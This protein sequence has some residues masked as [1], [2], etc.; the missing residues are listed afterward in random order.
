MTTIAAKALPGRTTYIG[1][2]SIKDQDTVLLVLEDLSQEDKELV[3]RQYQ[4]RYLTMSDADVQLLLD[5]YVVGG[6]N[7]A[8]TEGRIGAANGVAPLDSTVH[9]PAQY[10]PS[11][12]DDVLEFDNK[13]LFPSTGEAGKIYVDKS[14]GSTWRWSGTTYA[15]VGNTLA[16]GE[17]S[18]TAYPG[19]KGKIAYDHVTDLNNPHQTTKAHVGLS[20]VP[21]VDATSRASHTGTQ[22]ATTISDFDTTATALANSAISLR[23]TDTISDGVTDKAPTQNAVFDALTLKSNVGHVHTVAEVTNYNTVTDAK[24]ATAIAAVTLTSLPDVSDATPTTDQYLKYDGMLWSPSTLVFPTTGD[25]FKSTY[26]TND[27]GIVDNSEALSGFSS[28][29]HLDRNN[30]TGT[31]AK[32]TV[33]LSNVDNTSDV[34]KP[35]S[36]AQQTA[37][38]LKIN[39]SEKGAVNGV[40]P[41]GADQKVPAIY[42]PAYVDEVEEYNTLSEFPATS[43]DNKLYLAKDTNKLYRWTGTDYA[44]IGEGVALGETSSTAYAGD[45]GK[46]AYDHSQITSGNPHGTTKDMI[47]LSQVPNLDTSTTANIT[48]ST[49]KRFVTD[50][51]IAKLGTT[52]GTNTG[53]NTGDETQA[54]L[55]SKLGVATTGSDG[56]LLASD[57]TLFS[58]KENVSNKQNDLTAS[59]VKYPTVD[60]V[61]QGLSFKQPTL[62]SGTT[63]KTVNS[64]SL[65]GAGNLEVNLVQSPD[66]S[67]ARLVVDNTG[68]AT[69]LYGNAIRQAWKAGGVD[70]FANSGSTYEFRFKDTEGVNHAGFRAPPSVTASYFTVLPSS[71]GTANQLLMITGTGGG[72]Q[73]LG[74]TNLKTVN[75]LSLLGTG[76]VGIVIPKMWS[77]TATVAGGNG[78]ASFTIPAGI[79]TTPPTISATLVVASGA[80]VENMGSASIVNGTVTTTFGTV[81]AWT[82]TTTTIGGLIGGTVVSMAN[83]PNGAVVHIIAVQY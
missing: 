73:G 39:L 76:D 9:V 62:V 16:L 69:F 7:G 61:N 59:A 54:T 2:I 81:R 26:D 52:S 31:Q 43:L 78:L 65:L 70:M 64:T 83:A 53:T 80:A 19:D 75:G 55:K 21:N 38:D 46:I 36:T 71:I 48:D 32:S 27:N 34:D 5:S 6:T 82:G 47:G 3:Y 25:M 17:T 4:L 42:L 29:Y 63:L 12:V 11:Y 50:A 35:I 56:Y 79:F 33:G 23:I 44:F 37:L 51:Q 49:D 66:T 77:G 30:H 72:E 60:A 28:A 20:N 14:V 22:T 45:K 58:N 67:S 68:T 57:F 40:A 8:I 13:S 24:I 18:T 41:L 10:L 15:P 1:V 74:Y